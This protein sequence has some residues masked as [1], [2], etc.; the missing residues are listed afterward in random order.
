MAN[1]KDASLIASKWKR[2]SEN[3]G[4]EYEEGV[5][6][7]RTDWAQATSAAESAYDQGVQNA[8][9]R[10]AFG[11]GVRKAG[12]AKWQSN[13]LSKGPSRFSTGVAAAQQAYEDGFAPYRQTISALSLPAR[14]AK[15]D[16]KNIQRVAAVASALHAKKIELEGR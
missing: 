11:K 4:A 13:A 6:N 5:R 10:K 12:T 3:A 1:I 7:P 14:G 2:R 16:P 9:N 8:I 15:G